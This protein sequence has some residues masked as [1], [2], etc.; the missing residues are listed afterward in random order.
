MCSEPD[1]VGH[2]RACQAV[3]SAVDRGRLPQALLISG[4][5]GI[6]KSRF[7]RWVAA[8]CWCRKPQRPCGRCPTC[9]KVDTGNHPDLVVV[10]RD[11]DD[12]DG[13]GSR[14][15]IT[16]D[17]IRQRIVASLAVRPVEADGHCV[18][19]DGADEMNESAQNA[20]LKTLEEPSPGSL[21]L[22]VASHPDALLETV[23]SR[24]QELRLTPLD[25]QQMRELLPAADEQLLRLAAGRPGRL[26]AYEGLGV[27]VL[28]ELLQQILGGRLTA[29]GFARRVQE[30]LAADAEASDP[31]GRHRLAAEWML[32]RV[33]E[34]S[35]DGSLGV[36]AS[37]RAQKALFEV[38]A[39]LGRHIPPGVAWTA[40]GLALS[41]SDL[42]S[43][44]GND[45][46][47]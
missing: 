7:A 19:I 29:T 33:A 11:P 26:A 24:C 45:P 23:R 17:Q 35:A 2:E 10:A 12:P 6:G 47:Q 22:L 8:A 38:A 46:H 32:R 13:L 28:N 30:S 18:I 42:G 43:R 9:R 25:E 27:D 36:D 39:D 14:H 5:P 20:L 31:A 16:V 40:A 3:L 44:A 4:E 41:T 21:L 34:L 15:G 37:Q 1:L